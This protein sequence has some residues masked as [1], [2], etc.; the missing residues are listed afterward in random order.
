MSG[1]SKD[2]YEFNT[3]DSGLGHQRQT[4]SFTIGAP[5]VG[6][7][8]KPVLKHKAKSLSSHSLNVSGLT[9]PA[10]SSSGV[11]ATTT[12]T[13]TPTTTAIPTLTAALLKTATKTATKGK[14][15]LSTK[16]KEV[17]SIKGKE[18]LSTKGKEALSTKGKEALSSGGGGS[19][20]AAA[21]LL[22]QQQQR[23]AGALSQAL[24]GQ[25]LK[26]KRSSGSQGSSVHSLASGALQ[27]QSGAVGLTV[28]TM[29]AAA[30][31]AAASAVVGL[32]GA[33]RTRILQ[34]VQ[35]VQHQPQPSVSAMLAPVASSMNSHSATAPL[36]AIT[37]P[38]V[39]LANAA[40]YG[41]SATLPTGKPPVPG[42]GGGLV[43]HHHQQQQQPHQ[44]QTH[45]LQQ[46]PKG[47]I[48]DFNFVL[49]GLDPLA[50]GQYVNITGAQ[51]AELAA[52]QAVSAT[53][54]EDKG[55]KRGRLAVS[56]G[57]PHKLGLGATTNTTHKL[58]GALETLRALQHGGS[59]LTA[60][61]QNAV[62]LDG[63][64]LQ[65]AMLTPVSSLGG[66]GG[67]VGGG[68]G[69]VLGG[70]G[71][72]LGGVGGVGNSTFVALTS[73]ALAAASQSSSSSASSITVAP[74]TIFRTLSVSAV[75]GGGGGFLGAGF[76]G[77][78][79]M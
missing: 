30:A 69:G 1:N 31:G 39:N 32:A 10:S 7:M 73:S 43:V 50:N 67:G 23:R 17:L 26:R 62:L 53:V 44:Q 49:T 64:S 41:L 65:G 35:H 61:P 24:S 21:A 74:N 9:A 54:A 36:T 27:L 52:V 15:V 11:S 63:G 77:V 58:A 47:L 2:P 13:A 40:S 51:L 60:M 45:Q 28:T 20:A 70:V 75:L 38:S 8:G 66:A 76:S 34:H 78:L 68:G 4:V 25:T 72:M 14:E 3:V 22:K 56:G 33:D 42:G 59:V 6:L 57:V 48:K 12:P 46:L 37:I 55:V 29:G 16:G 18:V 71:G 5:N 19:T 79:R